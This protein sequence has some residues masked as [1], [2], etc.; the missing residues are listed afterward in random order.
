MTLYS[1]KFDIGKF[2]YSKFDTMVDD[3]SFNVMLGYPYLSKDLIIDT[4]L[5]KSEEISYVTDILSKQMN[6][7]RSYIFDVVCN[8]ITDR[9]YNIDTLLTKTESL[10]ELINTLIHKTIEEKHISIDVLLSSLN[11]SKELLFNTI[12]N[13]PLGNQLDMNIDTFLSK[14]NVQLSKVIDAILSIVITKGI[15]INVLL[16]SE[17][18]KNYDISSIMLSPSTPRELTLDSVLKGLLHSSYYVDMYTYMLGLHKDMIFDLVSQKLNVSKSYLIDMYSKKESINKSYIVDAIL[19]L[20]TEDKINFD[21]VIQSLNIRKQFTIDLLLSLL[22]VRPEYIMDALIRKD[23]MSNYM[24]NI[25]LYDVGVILSV[26]YILDIVTQGLISKNTVLDANLMKE[27]SKS[28]TLN[29]IIE[30]YYFNDYII[31]SV[32]RGD[33]VT[34][35]YIIDVMTQE[36]TTGTEYTFDVKLFFYK[37]IDSVINTLSNMFNVSA[38]YNALIEVIS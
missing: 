29:V 33:S 31:D 9:S 30:K 14:Y 34:S 23:I 28:T 1:A 8:L 24:F 21:T 26:P 12:L 11:I 22:G 3:L 15:N 36:E 20:V 5:T 16:K 35:R 19:Q 10:S 7:D 2:D 18:F 38:D 6:I 27:I 32:L 4:V 25:N 17:F 13:L 37:F